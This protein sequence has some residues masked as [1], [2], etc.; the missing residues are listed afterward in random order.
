MP[1]SMRILRALLVAAG[2]LVLTGCGPATRAGIGVTQQA[3]Q[4][5][6]VLY[7]C[8]DQPHLTVRV[9]YAQR[10]KANY[11]L[12]GHAKKHET[13]RVPLVA[14][15]A[16]WVLHGERVP[17]PTGHQIEVDAEDGSGS[18]LNASVYFDLAQVP[19]SPA[20]GVGHSKFE[21]LTALAFEKREASSC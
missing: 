13:V 14:S 11:T 21:I 16:A 3:G 1:L 17:L 2:M 15:S 9:Y 12:T 19:A 7:V 20:V 18:R 5:T 10:D 6:A 4:P 8:D